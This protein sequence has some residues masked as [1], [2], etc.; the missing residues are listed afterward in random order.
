MKEYTLI[1][2]TRKTVSLE[3]T[4][5]CRVVVRA[6]SRMPQAEIDR[7]FEKHRP[8]LQD[9][10][11]RQQQ[12]LAAHPEPDAETA[13]QLAREAARVLP[14]KVAFYG[15]QMGLT[16]SGITITGAR[17]RFGSCSPMN[18]LCFSWRLMQYPEAA[19][20]YVVVHELAHLVHRNHGPAFHA[21]V[22]SVLPDHR[23]RRNL[24]RE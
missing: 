17:T 22:A 23:A 16:P 5:N 12:R 2:S 24:L 18:R 20:D 6:P 21:L 1:R 13:A 15:K 10:L 3:V 9:H 7:F 8:W 14:E 4:R 11:A 19:I